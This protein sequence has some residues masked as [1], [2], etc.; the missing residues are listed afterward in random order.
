M[1]S[2]A[3]DNQRS[4]SYMWSWHTGEYARFQPRTA[5]FQQ[6]EAVKEDVRGVLEAALGRHS[7]LTE[8]NW[9]R[10][11]LA[12]QE[13]ELLVQKT[14]PGTAVSVIG[15][16][17]SYDTQDYGH[18]MP[19]CLQACLTSCVLQRAH[20]WHPGQCAVKSVTLI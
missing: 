13:C 1:R 8:G 20:Q 11:A 4:L 9:I 2:C 14:R 6:A 5:G 10:V 7:T 16:C 19:H 15:G 12:G 3:A 17:G 18:S